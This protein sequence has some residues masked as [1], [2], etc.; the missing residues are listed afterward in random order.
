MYL[1]LN[2]QAFLKLEFNQKQLGQKMFVPHATLTNFD[3]F[4][5]KIPPPFDVSNGY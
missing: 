3:V 5:S 1:Q 4:I 2:L